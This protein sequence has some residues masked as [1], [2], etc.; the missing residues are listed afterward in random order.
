MKLSVNRKGFVL[1]PIAALCVTSLTLLAN[2]S[3]GPSAGERSRS[4]YVG[5]EARP[6]KS[7]SPEDVN[8]LE[9]GRG[10]A[11]G[12]LAKLAELNGYPGPRHV[13]DSADQLHLTPEQTQVVERIYREM[14]QQS[15]TLGR[16]LVQ[17]ERDLDAAFA[18]AT[19]TLERLERGLAESARL[20]GELRNAHLQAHLITRDVLTPDQMRRYNGLRGYSPV[21]DRCPNVPAG[22]DP[23]MWRQHNGCE[24]GS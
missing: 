23:A 1:V 14:T 18:N 11:L 24:P 22:H 7:L 2:R 16:Q 19:V 17:H 9:A 21:E 12:G 10:D 8:A 20:Y 3:S 15:T 13:L 4:P 6:I 5:E